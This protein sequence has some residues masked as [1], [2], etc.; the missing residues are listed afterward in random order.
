MYKL[1]VIGLGERI[2]GVIKNLE[3]TGQ[4]ELA[5]VADPRVEEV[6]KEQTDK[7]RDISKI[8]FYP[9]AEEMLKIEKPDGIL[10]GTRCSL[11]TKYAKMV[12]KQGYPLFLEKPVC[13]TRED[14]ARL[15]K[16]LCDYPEECKRV[17]VSFPLRFTGQVLKVKELIADGKIG[18]IAHIQAWCNVPYALGYYHKWYRDDKETGGLFLQKATHDVDYIM[19][20]LGKNPTM[21][22]AMT[23]KQVFKGDHEAGLLCR[24]CAEKDTCI[25]STSDL[26]TDYRKH[27]YCCFAVDTGNED[28]GSA[29]IMFENGVHAAYSQNFISRKS[30]GKR[31]ARFIGH[32][33]TI[34]FDWQQE[35][36]IYHNHYGEK[37]EI[38]LDATQSGHFGGDYMLAVDFLKALGGE[39]TNCTLAEGIRSARLCLCLKESSEQQK[40]VQ[41]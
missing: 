35:Y 41:Y 33:G 1:G 9:T 7:G 18:E 6:K 39:E 13:T 32:L 23:S 14:L 8:K 3:L 15:E 16:L 27:D 17:T 5:F 26:G 2:S 28:S 36:I 10:I 19:D 30:A 21:V 12:L 40:F 29:V 4:C 37:E 11:H 31:G 22:C 25:D 34:E 20:I 38:P 24:N